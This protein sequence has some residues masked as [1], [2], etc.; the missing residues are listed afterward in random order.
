MTLHAQEQH[1]QSCW[2]HTLQR[3]RIACAARLHL[4]GALL[5]PADVPP[6]GFQQSDWLRACAAQVGEKDQIFGSVSTADIV[7]AIERQTG[8]QLD[9]KVNSFALLL[10]C[11]TKHSQLVTPSG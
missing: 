8:R 4:W 1:R 7:E 2:R 3:L 11:T 6:S 9:K 10:M 5:V